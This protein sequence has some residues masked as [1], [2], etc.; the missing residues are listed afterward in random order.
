MTKQEALE[1]KA[2]WALIE[3]REREELQKQSPDEK[4]RALAYLMASADLSTCAHSTPKTT[5]RAHGGT[6]A[7]VGAQ[8]PV[9]MCSTGFGCRSQR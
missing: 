3:Q 6:A 4:F 2:R 1:W 9:K 7:I 5:S 8:C